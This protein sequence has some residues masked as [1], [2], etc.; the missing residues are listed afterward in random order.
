MYRNMNAPT[1]KPTLHVIA[2]AVSGGASRFSVGLG[3]GVHLPR[4]HTARGA[5]RA[6]AIAPCTNN[7]R[8]NPEGILAE[9]KNQDSTWVAIVEMPYVAANSAP[10]S[11]Q[12]CQVDRKSTRLNSSHLGISY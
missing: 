6:I 3:A 11:L 1:S 4:I 9:R 5:N 2:V 8:I 7:A 12:P 10:A